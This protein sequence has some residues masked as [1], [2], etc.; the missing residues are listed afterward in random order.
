MAHSLSQ[1][2]RL[3]DKNEFEQYPANQAASES[4]EWLDNHIL[5]SESF[6][7]V[8]GPEAK[9]YTVHKAAFRGLSH[10][11][12]VLM[13]ALKLE[14]REGCVIWN[15]ICVSAFSCLCQFAYTKTYD[16]PAV[17]DP[18]P[19]ARI[20]DHNARIPRVGVQNAEN[21]WDWYQIARFTRASNIVQNHF[22]S[23]SHFLSRVEEYQPE[24]RVTFNSGL[25]LNPGKDYT[26]TPM[27]HA[28][29]FVLADRYGIEQLKLVAIRKLGEALFYMKLKCAKDVVPVIH[30]AVAHSR[31]KDCLR[32][33]LARYVLSVTRL[34][35][36]SEELDKAVEESPDFAVDIYFAM[37]ND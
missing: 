36:K 19:P 11:F 8:I 23:V 18:Q 35:K 28:K 6:V 15:D 12:K 10:Y 32:D 33:T 14:A 2:R 25:V 21:L 1:G 9:R 13:D 3:P 4:T 37:Q 29:V 16:A 17:P 22:Y 24:N 7:F 34:M 26:G 31:L 30:Y 27:C 20:F 5:N